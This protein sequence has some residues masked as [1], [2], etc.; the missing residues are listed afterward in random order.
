MG[1][2]LLSTTGLAHKLIADLKPLSEMLS[3]GDRRVVEKFFEDILRQ[4]VAIANATDLLPLES[5]LVII[6]VEE[7]QW[8]RREHNDLYRQIEELRHK[9]AELKPER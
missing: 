7:H 5:G 6:L 4:R 2:N 1:R 8:N 9:I 3:P